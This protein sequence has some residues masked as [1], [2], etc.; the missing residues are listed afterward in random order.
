MGCLLQE[1]V[2]Q[3]RLIMHREDCDLS[4]PP[5][6]CRGSVRNRN[7]CMDLEGINPTILQ[8]R[9]LKSTRIMHQHNLCVIRFRLKHD[10]ARSGLFS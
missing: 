5:Y 2:A 3:I 6:N 1:L 4:D 8:H 9:L 10:E 7:L